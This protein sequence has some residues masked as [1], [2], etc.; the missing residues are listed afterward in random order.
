MATGKYERELRGI[1]SG[2]IETLEEVTKTCDERE[3]EGYMSILDFPFLVV[4][5][6]GSL[7]MD[8]IAIRG[9]ISFPVEVKSSKHDVI[10][11]SDEE[12][13]TEQAEWMIDVC[14]ASKV[15]PLYA[16]RIKGRR[17]D[18]WRIFTLDVP[19]LR[20]KQGV[21]KRTVPPIEKTVHGNFTVRWK[22]GMPLHRFLAFL[23]HLL[24]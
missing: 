21:V 15:L 23:S 13:L 12:R 22:N 14:K 4:R 1:L 17:G 20:K 10:Y 19:D 2:D 9:E 5:A 11:F 3:K 8:L 16:F 6:G 18:R 24:S 7:G